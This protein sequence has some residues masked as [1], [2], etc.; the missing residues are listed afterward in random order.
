MY[1]IR[2]YMRWEYNLIFNPFPLSES[3]I[4]V[5]PE[6]LLG[7]PYYY[8]T[9]VIIVI[10]MCTLQLMQSSMCSNNAHCVYVNMLYLYRAT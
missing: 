5:C 1:I 10:I 7:E 4:H 2:V 6:T 8:I 3:Q 9:V